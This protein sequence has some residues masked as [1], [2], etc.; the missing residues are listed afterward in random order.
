MRRGPELSESIL[1]TRGW[2]EWS[3]EVLEE[4]P[5]AGSEEVLQRAKAVEKEYISKAERLEED[6]SRIQNSLDEA[7]ESI[8]EELE[9]LESRY[10]EMVERP[11]IDEDNRW[12]L[13]EERDG[14]PVGI[15]HDTIRNGPELSRKKV[16]R[17]DS[18]RS[19]AKD[20]LEDMGYEPG[21][22][23]EDLE[24]GPGGPGDG[25]GGEP[26]DGDDYD[27]DDEENGYRFTRRQVAGGAA[28]AA[29][30][31][32]GTGG[33]LLGRQSGGGA[34]APPAN[35]TATPTETPTDT[36]TDTPTETPTETPTDTPTETPTTP[37]QARETFGYEEFQDA[38][39]ELTRAEK[40]ELFNGADNYGNFMNGDLSDQEVES[41][42]IGYNPDEDPENSWVE[43]VIRDENDSFESDRVY[44]P[45]DLAEKILDV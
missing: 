39:D 5:D 16:D 42:Q 8:E 40:R 3:D 37:G 44:I 34:A 32:F 21:A 1:E 14:E 20:I 29:A 33:Y 28:A 11:Y 6:L 15:L 13:A 25:P 30:A 22:E 4:D 7:D 23:E 31:L 35:R 10:T 36:P 38:W 43:Y 17:L 27:G 41:V 19:R 2:E 18:L 45:D 9:E 12:I 24:G 26:G